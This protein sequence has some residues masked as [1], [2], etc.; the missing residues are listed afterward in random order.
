MPK[1]IF[2]PKKINAN[3]I[4]DADVGNSKIV[5]KIAVF[6]PLNARHD[7]A[8][9]TGQYEVF[10]KIN[11]LEEYEVTF[12]LANKDEYFAGVNN[13]YI[14]ANKIITFIARIYKVLFRKSFVRLP[15]Y[16]N[17]NF[18]NYDIVVTEGIHLLKDFLSL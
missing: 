16:D 18:N 3:Q 1:E 7:N 4:I 11:E 9:G 10:K 8:F 13:N 12:F 14:K 17:L 6:K 15:Y 5:K 2:L